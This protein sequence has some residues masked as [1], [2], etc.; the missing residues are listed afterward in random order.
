MHA[1][2]VNTYRMYW[3]LFKVQLSLYVL[4]FKLLLYGSQLILLPG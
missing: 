2:P 1:N 4:L 3:Y